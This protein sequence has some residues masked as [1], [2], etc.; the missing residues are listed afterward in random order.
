MV[1]CTYPTDLRVG[2][3]EMNEE[4]TIER[5][6]LQ[7]SRQP[8]QTQT[9]SEI[10][11]PNAGSLTDHQIIA[12]TLAFLAAQKPTDITPVDVLVVVYLI[13][14]RAFD[15]PINDSQYTMSQRLGCEPKTI[16]R[17]LE[18]LASPQINWITRSKRQGRS[19]GLALIHDNLPLADSERLRITQDA[20]MLAGRYQMALQKA[21]R[22][23]FPKGWLGQ[24]CVS[25]QR[26]LNHCAGDLTL[27]R[28]MVGHAISTP[29][30]KV[31]ARQSLYHL[32]R[33]WKSVE[34]SYSTYLQKQRAKQDA[35][36]ATYEVHV[37]TKGE[38]N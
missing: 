15:H 33:R 9:P 17:S 13:Q 30:H 28:H 2:K 4:S 25:A 6:S 32:L 12:L 38:V 37:P 3:K 16:S 10:E 8:D 14:R 20:K 24:Q 1:L 22:R 31:A 36:D 35:G 23:R 29:M 19:D 27:S 11:P 7:S 21:G 18:R 34:V 5:Q 26:I